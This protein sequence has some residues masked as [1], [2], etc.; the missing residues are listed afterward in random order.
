MP[1]IYNGCF[2]WVERNAIWS[3]SLSY[4]SIYLKL[5][6]VFQLIPCSTNESKDKSRE[7]TCVNIMLD[8]V[9]I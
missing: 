4:G 1:I 7:L 9:T 3:S 5:G 2:E 8:N 6:M